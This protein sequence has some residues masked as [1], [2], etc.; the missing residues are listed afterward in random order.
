MTPAARAGTLIAVALLVPACNL[1][2]T[3][4]DPFAT[5][6]TPQNPFTL[7]FPVDGA[8]GVLTSNTQFGWGALEGAQSYELQ[9]SETPGFAQILYDLPNITIP[10]V[11][12]QVGLTCQ[13][14][15]YWRIFAHGGQLL[16]HRY[17]RKLVERA[18]RRGSARHRRRRVRESRRLELRAR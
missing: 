1:T 16:L 15:Y 9:I 18:L 10:S 13:T 8:T 11:F 7:Q 14:T 12:I 6:S 4:D 17:T 5:S 2:F 3:S